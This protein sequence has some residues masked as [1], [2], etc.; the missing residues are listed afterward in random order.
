LKTLNRLKNRKEACPELIAYLSPTLPDKLHDRIIDYMEPLKID[1][2]EWSTANATLIKFVRKVQMEWDDEEKLFL[3]C[4]EYKKDEEWC[5]H[6]LDAERFIELTAFDATGVAWDYHLKRIKDSVP[7]QKVLIL[8]E[9][10]SAVFSQQKNANNRIRVQHVRNQMGERQ[11]PNSKDSDKYIDLNIEDV[12]NMLIKM[13][14]VQELRITYTSSTEES[15]E[16]I[17]ILA[18]DIA[19][20]PY[21]F[22]NFHLKLITDGVE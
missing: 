21:R 22:A 8:L 5:I 14:L 19:S 7:G 12:Q 2:R 16:W 17:S 10:L 9:G 6:W 18:T 3:P 13:Q 1:T 11:R 15:A 4:E 20:I